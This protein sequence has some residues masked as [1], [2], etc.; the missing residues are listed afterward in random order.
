[1]EH[2]WLKALSNKSGYIIPLEYSN[3]NFNKIVNNSGDSK[4]LSFND[5]SGVN[6][7]LD[8]FNRLMNLNYNNLNDFKEFICENKF[9]KG[10]KSNIIDE[11]IFG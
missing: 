7:F 5:I 11:T 10:F 4:Y 9:E 8:Y 2:Y 6:Y 1:M 3:T